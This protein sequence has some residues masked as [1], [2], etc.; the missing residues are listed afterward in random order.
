MPDDS[1]EPVYPLLIQSRLPK[2]LGP[3]IAVAVAQ[4]LAD[5]QFSGVQLP[6]AQRDELPP[7]LEEVHRLVQREFARFKLIDDLD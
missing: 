1:R 4:Q 5:S 7:P 3:Q 2:R 6:F